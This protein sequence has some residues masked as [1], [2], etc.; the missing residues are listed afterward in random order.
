[1][2]SRGFTRC[3][4]RYG[5]IMDEHAIVRGILLRAGEGAS[6]TSPLAKALLGW[7][8]QNGAWLIGRSAAKLRWGPFL[9][10]LAER[11]ALRDRRPHA[12][13]LAAA[14]G[15]LLALDPFDARLLEIF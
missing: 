15:G 4:G 11:P 3:A 2:P 8:R 12:L 6:A 14:L 9:A 13:D 5:F 1:M 7:A 10:A